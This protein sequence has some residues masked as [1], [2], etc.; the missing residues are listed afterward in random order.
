MRELIMVEVQAMQ[1]LKHKNIIEQIEVGTAPYE[2]GDGTSKVVS[3]IVMEN[4]QGGE[5]FDFIAN[6]G[7]FTEAEARY[8]FKQFM[9]GLNYC[10]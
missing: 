5:L 8:F 10:H 3:Y 7:Q 1:K 6:S 2:K 4:A 9:D